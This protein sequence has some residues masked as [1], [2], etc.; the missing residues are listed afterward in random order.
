MNRLLNLLLELGRY[1]F[2]IAIAGFGVN[3]IIYGQFRTGLP[4]VPPW[5]PGGAVLSYVVGAALVVAAVSIAAN[6]KVRSS[7]AVVPFA[8]GANLIA[9]GLSVAAKAKARL[10]AT[11]LGA[12]FVFCAV[13]L[14]GTHARAILLS[15]DERT[16][17]FEALSIGAA[18][19]VLAATVPGAGGAV[20]D[21]VAG[22]LA[23]AGRYL[24][25]ISMIIFGVQHFMLAEFIA[26]LIPG[27]MPAR[28]FLA[29]FTGVAFIAAGLAIATGVLARLG[30]ALLGVM[31]LLWVLL[32]HGPRVAAALRNDDEWAS[33]FVAL[34]I[35][36]G[37][38]II[39]Q[40][41]QKKSNL[42]R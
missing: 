23:T 36:G 7:S 13:C 5:I 38:F 39:A 8:V 17:A 24:F 15:G 21:E 30:S 26:S 22:K 20:S 1:F 33:L 19:W 3:Y 35:S 25:A 28:L 18:A 42:A 27:W 16:G 32:L 9:A 12:L 11:L 40:G 29:Y 31:F 4:P 14:H 34:A 2:A 37:G 6:G 41:A 10:S